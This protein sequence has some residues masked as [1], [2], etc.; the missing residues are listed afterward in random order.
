MSLEKIEKLPKKSDYIQRA[1]SNPFRD[2]GFPFP[3]SP[4]KIDWSDFFPI[5]KSDNNN[6]EEKY[7]TMLD[8]GCGYGGTTI[9]LSNKY[10]KKLILAFEIRTIVTSY[11]E[12][13]LNILYNNNLCQ[14]CSV[15]LCNVMRNLTRYIKSQTIEK[16][17]ILFPDPH[18]KNR[19]AKRRIITLQLLDEYAYVLKKKGRLYLTTDVRKYFNEA[20]EIFDQHPLFRIVE[21]PEDDECFELSKTSSEESDRVKKNGGTIFGFIYERVES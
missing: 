6:I 20:K 16:M 3:I 12:D 18:F 10:P 11:L 13:K 14:N 2:R 5:L 15:Q 21:N 17:F 4:E 8:I 9:E 1:H 7:P 19:N